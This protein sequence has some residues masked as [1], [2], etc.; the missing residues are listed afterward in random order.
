[1][2][3]VPFEWLKSGL[4]KLNLE[5]NN[6][7]QLKQ[8]R[9]LFRGLGQANQSISDKEVRFM[10]EFSHRLTQLESRAEIGQASFTKFKQD[11]L[12][13]LRVELQTANNI[14]SFI[15]SAM[16]DTSYQLPFSEHMKRHIQHEFIDF[17]QD[18]NHSWFNN[19]SV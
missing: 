10:A 6:K 2:L 5:L 19:Y 8:E 4:P 11:L 14:S 17:L 7:M 15:E 1:M 3:I 16:P 18:Y 13:A 12:T 9:D